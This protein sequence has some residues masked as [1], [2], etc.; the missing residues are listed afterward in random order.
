MVIFEF[1]PQA[2]AT[3]FSLASAQPPPSP[4][5]MNAVQ[6]LL[7]AQQPGPGP[8]PMQQMQQQ[9]QSSFHPPVNNNNFGGMGNMGNMGNS[10]MGNNNMGPPPPTSTGL[11][12]VAAA[13]GG[14]TPGGSQIDP[15]P[16]ISDITRIAVELG[17]QRLGID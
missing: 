4:T 11:T 1:F 3:I 15:G 6:R 17:K 14:T 16:A 9:Q 10:N 8:Q 5:P 12:P 7:R 13:F 2:L